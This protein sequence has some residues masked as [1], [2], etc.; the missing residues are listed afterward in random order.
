MPSI[1]TSQSRHRPLVSVIALLP[2]AVVGLSSRADAAAPPLDGAPLW[3]VD[4]PRAIRACAVDIID[5]DELLLNRMHWLR[6][7]GN[8]MS[9][10]TADTYAKLET[11]N[12]RDVVVGAK[13]YPVFVVQKADGTHSSFIPEDNGYYAVRVQNRWDATSCDLVDGTGVP[14]TVRVAARCDVRPAPKADAERPIFNAEVLADSRCDDTRE[15]AWTQEAINIRRDRNSWSLQC[16]YISRKTHDRL[17]FETDP[18]TGVTTRLD[19]WKF[20]SYAKNDPA[21]GYP[22]WRPEDYELLKKDENGVFSRCEKPA[23]VRPFAFC[24]IGCYAPEQR[25]TFSTGPTRIDEAFEQRRRDIVTL[26]PDAT[27]EALKLMDNRVHSYI[28][29]VLPREQ[30]L[31]TFTMESG[32]VLRVTPDHPIVDEEGMVRAASEFQNGDRLVKADG[33]FDPIRS[34][35]K[36]KFFGKVYNVQPETKDP[37]SNVVIAEGY[38]NASHKYQSPELRYMNRRLVRETVDQ[39]LL[40]R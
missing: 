21:N 12:G 36:G 25:I 23:D 20:V 1:Q 34:I 15:Q 5:S 16:G 13:H 33:T 11:Q 29:D 40:P 17:Y 28:A 3:S 27:F 9:Q 35:V 19:Q 2:L 6:S 26:A 22:L 4:D 30:E 18:R 39:A 10:A 31:L 14:M 37:T 38:L 24:K 7:C 32:G 8:L